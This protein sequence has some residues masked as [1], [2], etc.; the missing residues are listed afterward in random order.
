MNYVIIPCFN[1]PEFLHICLEQIQKSLGWEDL[2]YVFAKDWGF[3]RKINGI[4][5]R[6]PGKKRII[7]ISHSR[8][9]PTK[10]SYNVLNAYVVVA[11]QATGYVF[12]IEEDVFIGRDFFDWHLEIH[13]RHSPFCSIATRNH[14][15]NFGHEPDPVTYYISQNGDYQ[16]LGVCFKA[17]QIK[18]H[19]TP[20]FNQLYFAQPQQYCSVHFPDSKIGSSFVE[21]DGL[22][23]RII[24]KNNLSVAFP[25]QPRAFHAGFYGKNRGMDTNKFTVEQLKKICFSKEEMRKHCENDYFY[26]DSEPEPLDFAV[27]P[28]ALKLI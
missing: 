12:M 21:Q 13:R 27:P 8:N 7:E 3:N 19:I 14:N 22:I 16:S 9:Y 26:F 23:R 18:K 11:E 25:T 2:T 10:Q 6:F 28:E 15:T 20:H 5:D 17:S 24:E 1:R 4:I